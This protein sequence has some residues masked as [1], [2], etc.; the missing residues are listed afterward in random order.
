[1]HTHYLR[2]ENVV[3]VRNMV[4][5][6]FIN[7]GNCCSFTGQNDSLVK[8]WL[9]HLRHSIIYLLKLRQSWSI[10]TAREQNCSYREGSI[11]CSFS[12]N[13]INYWYHIVLEQ[14][15]GVPLFIECSNTIFYYG[16]HIN[17]I[18]TKVYENGTYEGKIWRLKDK[19]F[20]FCK[21]VCIGPF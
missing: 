8:R 1:M 13:F 17:Y 4:F 6:N 19:F 10:C 20:I 2:L 3:I 16:E 12:F 7:D 15:L 5:F 9:F 21:I 11:L 14:R 18:R